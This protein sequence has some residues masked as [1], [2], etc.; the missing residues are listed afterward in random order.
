MEIKIG[1][2]AVFIILQVIL[3]IIFIGLAIDG[4]GLL[5]KTIATLGLNPENADKFWKA[6]D[7]TNVY[8][9]DESQYVMLS[10]IVIIV[11]FLK[12]LLFY[13]IIRITLNNNF[14]MTTP[15]NK[16]FRKFILTLAYL[17]VGIG[18]FSSWGIKIVQALTANGLKLQDIQQ[19]KIDGAGVW[20][21]MAI[22][23]LVIAQ[24]FKRGIELQQ[25]N[26]LT[27]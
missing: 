8:Q 9:F 26:E 23:L 18:F 5:V 16:I 17:A 3:W 2:K 11:I 4:T 25:E 14:S 13:S 21:F 7:L 15:F 24:I 22:I 12:V 20:F 10:S 1:S 19:L 27:I 6:I